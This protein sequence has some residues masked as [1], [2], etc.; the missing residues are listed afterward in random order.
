MSVGFASE[1]L[2]MI[3]LRVSSGPRQAIDL[4]LQ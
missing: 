1:G 3:D 2:K 4:T